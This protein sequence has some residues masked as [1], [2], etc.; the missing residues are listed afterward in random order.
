ME[1]E[2]L[3]PPTRKRNYY[4]IR[5]SRDADDSIARPKE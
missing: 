1:K 5:Q 2:H 4:A 3:T